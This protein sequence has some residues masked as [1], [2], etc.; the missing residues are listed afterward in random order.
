L[1]VVSEGRAVRPAGGKLTDAFEPYATH[2]YTTDRRLAQRETIAQ[3]QAQVDQANAARRK[4]G[5]LAFEDLGAKVEVS[6]K[7]TYGSTPDRV[8]DGVPSGMAWQDGTRNAN[9]GKNEFPDWIAVAFPGEQ[10]VA[11]VVVYT[12]TLRDYDVQVKQGEDWRTVAQ[13]RGGAEASLDS[14]FEAV[15]TTAVRLLITA[16]RDDKQS[17]RVYEIEVYGP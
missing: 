8:V 5:N 1:F 13:V 10:T 3:T 7:S 17:S 9:S 15:K 11:R 12:D 2:I 6:S 14:R 16:T 4:S